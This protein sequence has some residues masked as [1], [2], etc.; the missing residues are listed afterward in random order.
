MIS[1]RHSLSRFLPSAAIAI[2]A[3]LPSPAIAATS[4]G[5]TSFERPEVTGLECGDGQQAACPRG[6]V[7]HLEGTALDSTKSVRFLG[8]KGR[9]DDRVARPLQRTATNVLVR[10]PLGARSGSLKLVTS[11]DPVTTPALTVLP[12]A[13]APVAPAI[14]QASDL[15]GV[16]PIRGEYEFGKGAASFGGGRG[17]QGWDVFAK[18]GTPLVAAFAGTVHMNAFQAR[19]G[20]YLVIDAADG[21]SQAYMH[22]VDRSTL[23]KGDTVAAGDPIGEVGQTGRASGCHLHFELWT[24][25]GWYRG[26]TAIDPMPTLKRLAAS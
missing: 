10:V 16:F 17:H 3:A 20:N 19:A 12:R 7:L 1:I 26:G 13:A 15:P 23:K 18:C 25:P 4:A 6:Q 2:A 8:K 24:A 14:V 22:M 9:R 21:T 11:T 5:G